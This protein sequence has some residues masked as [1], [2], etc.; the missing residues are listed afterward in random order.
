MSGLTKAIVEVFKA[1]RPDRGG[2]G[3]LL[4]G[5][6]TS[7]TVIAA[8]FLRKLPVRPL[9]EPAFTLPNGER[10]TRKVCG[11]QVRVSERVGFCSVRFGEVH[12]QPVLDAAALEELG[13]ELAPSARHLR[14]AEP[15]L[16]CE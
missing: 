2:D 8:D 14:P 7:H 1:E 15:F 3:E 13:R 9:E 10:I 4:L 6:G 5:S 11:V 16:L 12:D